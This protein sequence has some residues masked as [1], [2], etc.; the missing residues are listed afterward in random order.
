MSRKLRILH[1]IPTVEG[2]GAEHVIV[3][4]LKY[5]PSDEIHAALLTIYRPPDLPFPFEIL[6]AGRKNRQDRFFFGRLVRQIRRFKP[7]I[8]HTHTRGG[9]YW[10]R[11]AAVLAGVPMIVHTEHNPCDTRKKPLERLGDFVL[12][13]VTTR[14]VTF[15]REQAAFWAK[16]EGIPNEKLAVIPNGLPLP[17][18]RNADATDTRRALGLKPEQF[19]IMVIA[20]LHAQKNQT[21]VLRAL[22]EIQE[23][24]RDRL[25]VFFVGSGEDEV[26]LRGLSR[27]LSLDGHVRFLG[28]RND[29][30]A[31]LNAADL[32]LMTSWFEG[33]PLAL[34]EAMIAGVPIVT[35]PWVG[36][37]NM[38]GDGRFG[39]LTANYEA[40]QVASQIE[41]ALARPATRHDV[42]MRAQ[43][44]AYECY[45]ISQMADAHRRLYRQLGAAIS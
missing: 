1:V 17:E 11:S 31:L 2:Y 33:M 28:Y 19:A 20:R 39:F 41:R 12:H 25:M 3:E 36:A 42:A 16:N 9:R 44:H 23:G 32:L 7:D 10:G 29:V 43:Q 30:D 15:F 13:R 21:L 6:T 45:G 27:A 18:G 4:L 35:T 22:A 26:L 34:I 37:T 40:K 14:F 24:L 8:V 38:L 5:L